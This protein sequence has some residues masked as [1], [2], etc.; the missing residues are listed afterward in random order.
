MHQVIG[1]IGRLMTVRALALAEEHVLSAHF[2]RRRL[3]GIELAQQVELGRARGGGCPRRNSRTSV[4]TSGLEPDSK[5][6]ARA[7]RLIPSWIAARVTKAARVPP[8]RGRA[9]FVNRAPY[10]REKSR[11][12]PDRSV[13][14]RHWE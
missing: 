3:G 2:G 10:G 9:K 8:L 6:Y 4:L 12:Q 11:L 14:S 5:A 13:G 1:V 7:S